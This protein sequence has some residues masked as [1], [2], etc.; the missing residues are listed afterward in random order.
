[1]EAALPTGPRCSSR[2]ARAGVA[3]ADRVDERLAIVDRG[4]QE[5]VACWPAWYLSP[6]RGRLQRRRTIHGEERLR[7]DVPAFDEGPGS[8]LGR[9][10]RGHLLGQALGPRLRRL[11]QAIL[12]LVHRR[13]L[14]YLLH[15][16]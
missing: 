13:R 2:P 15:L 11:A 6:R 1:M 8:L 12:P 9:G 5:F 14:Q 16:G 3:G 4:C 10:R 7:R